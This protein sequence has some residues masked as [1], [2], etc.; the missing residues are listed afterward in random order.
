MKKKRIWLKKK[1]GLPAEE[2]VVWL[3]KKNWAFLKKKAALAD[4]VDLE[5]LLQLF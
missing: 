5:Q 3:M 1:W 4:V 2:E